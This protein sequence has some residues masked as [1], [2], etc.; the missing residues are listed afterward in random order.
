M[1]RIYI[2]VLISWIIFLP[3]YPSLSQDTTPAMI[4][5]WK[6][7]AK[8][9]SII[10]PFSLGYSY[11]HGKGVEKNLAEAAKWYLLGAERGDFQAALKLAD[12][13]LEGKGVGKD[14]NR[15]IEWYTRI[16]KS[17][18]ICAAMGRL[19]LLFL[20]RNYS[21]GGQ[22]VEPDKAK[23]SALFDRLFEIETAIINREQAKMNQSSEKFNNAL[24][25]IEKMIPKDN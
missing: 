15:A 6:E 22:G 10:G 8:K 13:Y 11:E 2:F 12:M 9:G 20:V 4:Q 16:G 23:A 3:A 21:L 1:W 25:T 7:S 17:E 19:R 18:S 14:E 5:S 24:D